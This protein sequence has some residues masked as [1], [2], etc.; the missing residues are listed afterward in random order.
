MQTGI[1]DS[2]GVLLEKAGREAI[3]NSCM[4][5]TQDRVLYLL[6]Y[7]DDMPQ[8]QIQN[9]LVIKPGS[10]SEIMSKLES[11]GLIRRTKSEEDRRV[12]IVSL[13]EAGRERAAEIESGRFSRGSAFA[14]L[15]EEEQ[16]EL[17]QLLEKLL[18]S[19]GQ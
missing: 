6:K 16:A 9:I 1:T 8:K 3:H 4:I 15:S 19:W 7:H 18:T 12:V 14:A 17:R 2:L 10:A 5:K 13:T 11:K